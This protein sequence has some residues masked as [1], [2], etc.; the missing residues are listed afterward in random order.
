MLVLDETVFYRREH[1]PPTTSTRWVTG[2]RNI[3][4]CKISCGTAYLNPVVLR[5]NRPTAYHIG[6]VARPG[7]TRHAVVSSEAIVST[8]QYRRV[9]LKPIPDDTASRTI[10]LTSVSLQAY[11]TLVCEVVVIA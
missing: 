9:G 10:P 1:D 4:Y 8:D 7:P 3:G 5:R 2:N 11:S 6:V